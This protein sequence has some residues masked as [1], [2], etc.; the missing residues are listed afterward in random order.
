[1]SPAC[2]TATFPEVR[3]LALWVSTVPEEDET[4]KGHNHPRRPYLHLGLDKIL[5]AQTA[6]L[7]FCHYAILHYAIQVYHERVLRTYERDIP[8]SMVARHY[9]ISLE[10][11]PIPSPSTK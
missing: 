11:L 1:M 3:N 6:A 2:V 7:I 9:P 4:G 10:A 8:P 5:Q